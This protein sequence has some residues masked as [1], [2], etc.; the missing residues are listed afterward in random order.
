MT[1]KRQRLEEELKKLFDKQE[2]VAQK[3]RETQ[4]QIMEETNTEIHEMVHKAKISPEQLAEI[5]V[6][7][8]GGAN[9]GSMNKTMASEEEKEHEL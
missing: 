8:K 1:K 5:L 3:I 4:D 2:E 7:F 6:A 9:P